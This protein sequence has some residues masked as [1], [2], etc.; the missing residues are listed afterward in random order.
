MSTVRSI[1]NIGCSLVTTSGAVCRGTGGG[2][3]PL[4][5]GEVSLEE[6][7]CG[8]KEKTRTLGRSN[9]L[10]DLIGGR[11]L[12][13]GLHSHAIQPQAQAQALTKT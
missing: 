6:E 10:R 7:E 4:L 2:I 11:P 1:K 3:I 5:A 13:V 9:Q 12:A 8:N